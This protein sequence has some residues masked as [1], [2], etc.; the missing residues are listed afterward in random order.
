MAQHRFFLLF[1]LLLATPLLIAAVDM[2]LHLDDPLIQQVVS[3][4]KV[5]EAEA[6]HFSRFKLQFDKSYASEEEH[7]YRFDVFKANLRR[8]KFHQ[9]LDPE[10]VHGV[11]KFS[12]LTPEEF[13]SRYLGLNSLGFGLPDDAKTAPTLPTEDLPTDFDW[14]EK[15]AVTGV[16]DQV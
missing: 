15:G 4:D 1:G 10:A 9:K 3:D 12:D 16:K 6:H 2:S 13:Q 14:R 8:A 5:L 11:T 7:D